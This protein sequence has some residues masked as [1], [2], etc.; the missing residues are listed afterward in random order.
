M[1]GALDVDWLWLGKSDGSGAVVGAATRPDEVP[2]SS[3]VGAGIG[4]DTSVLATAP[5][6][7]C[8]KRNTLRCWR[9]SSR[10]PRELDKVDIE[11]CYQLQ[12]TR[13]RVSSQTLPGPLA[14]YRFSFTINSSCG[15]SS[16]SFDA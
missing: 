2:S 14:L 7:S 4:T 9:I 8:R 13:A 10:R 11:P 5:D 15:P 16:R 12:P 1:P 6:Q 3:F